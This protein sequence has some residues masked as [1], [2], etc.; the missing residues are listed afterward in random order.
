MCVSKQQ[1]RFESVDII[2]YSL[3]AITK[4][5]LFLHSHDIYDSNYLGVKD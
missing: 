1:C 5:K 3:I 2:A 4:N